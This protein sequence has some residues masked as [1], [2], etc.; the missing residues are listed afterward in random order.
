MN[1]LYLRY[2]LHWYALSTARLLLRRWH[3]F[4][5]VTALLLPI[6]GGSLLKPLSYPLL[7][8]LAPA[9]DAG[10]RLGYL[11]LL[12][13]IW[14]IWALTQRDQIGGGPCNRYLQSLPL[15]RAGARAV[16]LAVLLIADTPLLAPVVCTLIVLLRQAVAPELRLQQLLYLGAIAALMLMAQ[17]AALGRQRML[18]L[19]LAL[20]DLGLAAALGMDPTPART[21]SLAGLNGAVAALLLARLP[22]WPAPAR[23]LGRR[24]SAGLDRHGRA[25]LWRLPPAMQVSLG[26]LYR[27]RRA[28]VVAAAL[29][30]SAISAAALLL[31]TLWDYDSRAMPMTLIAFACLA[32]GVSGLY[33]G[34]HQAHA[35]AARFTAALPRPPGWAGWYDLGAVL[36]FSL[37]FVAAPGAMLLRHGA[38][39][40]GPLLAA[41]AFVPLLCLLR[42]PQVRA[43]RHAVF[44]SSVIAL[45]WLALLFFFLV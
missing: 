41:A 39:A 22:A 38:A 44:F 36:S 31:M 26:I 2:R 4:A 30:A 18:W 15:G 14:A 40:G 43:E 8:P 13:L 1:R 27:Q 32:L 11:A 35:A 6:G 45:S 7:A 33:R 37:P 21:A 19:A 23:S 10:W 28:E 3:T 17:L 24:L 25:L 29:L 9:H 34:L 42:L 20:A 5:L 12:Q 16:D